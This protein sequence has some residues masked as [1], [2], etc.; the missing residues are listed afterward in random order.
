L[1]ILFVCFSGKKVNAHLS[2]QADNNIAEPLHLLTSKIFQ[3][4]PFPENLIAT[5]SMKAFTLQYVPDIESIPGDSKGGRGLLRFL[6]RRFS[7]ENTK[8]IF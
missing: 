2:S 8:H 4:R 1:T 5:R 6:C 3:S 7:S